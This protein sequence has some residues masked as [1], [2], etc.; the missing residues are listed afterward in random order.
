MSGGRIR[1]V[2]VVLDAPGDTVGA[3]IES[4]GW[5]VPEAPGL[6]VTPWYVDARPVRGRF[7]IT[8]G[9]SGKA[10]IDVPMCAHDARMWIEKAGWIGVDWRADEQEIMSSGPARVHAWRVAD[11]WRPH[12]SACPTVPPVDDRTAQTLGRAR[13]G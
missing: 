9:A 3:S 4:A 8:H 10:L 7:A 2:R 12:C 11:E 13:V 1:P 5:V 6:L